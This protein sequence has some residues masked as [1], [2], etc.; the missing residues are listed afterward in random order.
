MKLLVRNIIGLSNRDFQIIIFDKYCNYAARIEFAEFFLQYIQEDALLV[1]RVIYSDECVL[2]FD[3]KFN[4]Q[5]VWILG[6]ENPHERIKTDRDSK[7]VA[8]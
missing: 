3:G 2:Q 8:V 7:Q 5:K 1:T 4:K 6:T